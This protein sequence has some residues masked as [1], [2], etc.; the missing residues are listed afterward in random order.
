MNIKDQYG[1]TAAIDRHFGKP[2]TLDCI[3]K[4]FNLKCIA[5]IWEDVYLRM[6]LKD[7]PDREI[8]QLLDSI[9]IH[10]GEPCLKTE[11]T[12]GLFQQTMLTLRY[13]TW[14]LEKALG[15]YCILPEYRMG[16]KFPT[17]L[18]ADMAAALILTFDEYIPIIYNRARKELLQHQ[19]RMITTRVFKTTVMSIIA[20]LVKEGRVLLPGKAYV[21]A[22][23]P[24]KVHIHFDNSP[25]VIVCCMESVE[26]RLIKKYGK[27][28]LQ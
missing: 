6:P 3:D 7:T 13:G 17:R 25:D 28:H 20:N 14:Y 22:T 19:E 9:R 8:D 27:Q 11:Q 16:S 1:I 4:V 5:S 23:D 15:G 10:S 26:E 18:D 2:E 12:F 21:V 24:K